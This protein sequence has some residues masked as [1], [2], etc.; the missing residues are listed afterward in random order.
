M[1]LQNIV[2]V[3]PVL[4]SKIVRTNIMTNI[5]R[6][7]HTNKHTGWKHYHLAI[8]GDKKNVV[9]SFIN[10]YRVSTLRRPSDVINDVIIMKILFWHNLG[11]SI[12]MWGQ[13]EAVFNISNFSKWPQ[14]WARD[15]LFLPEVIPEVEYTRNIAM[16]ISDVL[17]FLI[18]AVA[19]ILT[20][21]Y[22]FQ[23]LTYFV[24][25]WRHQWRHEC[26]KHNLHN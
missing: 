12:H 7:P 22:Q 3:A 8:A 5:D 4:H 14:F 1:Y 26:V 18:D 20:E 19:Q 23:N 2:C 9:I 16:S 21:I 13:I 17:S 11:R 6:Q 24:I 25:L 15:K 10:E